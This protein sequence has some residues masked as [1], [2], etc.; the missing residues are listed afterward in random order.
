MVISYRWVEERNSEIIGQL[1]DGW[2]WDMVN[3]YEW[4]GIV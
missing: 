4:V 1:S 2:K 3:S